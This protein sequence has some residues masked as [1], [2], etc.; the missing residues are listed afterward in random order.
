M[1][2]ESLKAAV[3]KT[4]A[5]GGHCLVVDPATGEILAMA[6]VPE[7]NPNVFSSFR[8]DQW[9]N[10]TVTDCFEPGST[11]K[12]FLLSACLEEGVVTPTTNFDCEK[13]EFKIGA[14]VVH[15]TKRHG[16]MNV[17]DIIV[18]SSNI[19]AIKIGHKLGYSKFCEYL[20]RFGFGSRT[21][22]DLLGERSGFLRPPEK[23]GPVDQATLFFGQGM[24]T[25]SLQ[26]AMAMSAIANGGKL[27]RPYVVREIIDKSG[28][29]VRRT[30]PK[31]VRRVI[32][33]STAR[34]A[35][36][37]LEGVVG[38]EGTG[39]Q[40]AISGFRVAG[41][42]GTAQ[43]VDPKTRAYSE[44]LSVATF[45]GFVPMTQPKLVI[46]VVIDEPKGVAYGG[47]VAGPV[48]REVGLW[49][50]NYLRVNPR[51]HRPILARKGGTAPAVSKTAGP[52]SGEK[53]GGT[54][55]KIGI[56]PLRPARAVPGALSSGP[57]GRLSSPSAPLLPDFR[58]LGMRVVL[59]RGRSLGLKI[60]LEGTGLA[61]HQ[62]PGPGTPLTRVSA[63]RVRFQPPSQ[64][65]SHRGASAPG[66]HKGGT[67]VQHR[68]SSG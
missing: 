31:L 33:E 44:D 67:S 50:L 20:R 66:G 40:A 68:A 12:A 37:I 32:S 8:P 6:V 2:Q 29:R 5:R 65:V 52:Q 13:G 46:L 59:K 41:K 62:D 43:K 28:R 15:D 3:K 51:V 47:V 7:F 48:F 18:R 25:T 64:G 14:H 26:M 55:S 63:V 30:Y 54:R 23:A 22:I 49:S 61:V 60:R 45:L 42:T 19:G 11:I 17:R 39:K 36:R 38:E 56:S 16:V 53:M 10:R 21:G 35:A 4:G 1:A 24:T 57:P 27:M 58:G 9:R 34:K